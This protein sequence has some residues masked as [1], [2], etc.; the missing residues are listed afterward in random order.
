[1]L[2]ARD[3]VA[4]LAIK[5]KWQ[6]QREVGATSLHGCSLVKLGGERRQ[7]QSLCSMGSIS[8]G[9]CT[10]GSVRLPEWKC[11]ALQNGNGVG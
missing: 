2:L 9:D 10:M 3:T 4:M 11:H 5:V 8:H 1:M 6:R 7:G